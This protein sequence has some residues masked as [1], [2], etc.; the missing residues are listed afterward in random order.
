LFAKDNNLCNDRDIIPLENSA[1]V[2]HIGKRKA[3]ATNDRNTV[4]L[5]NSANVIHIGRRIENATI[6]ES[7]NNYNT[8]SQWRGLNMQTDVDANEYGHLNVR[9]TAFHDP[10]YSHT[11]GFQDSN[12]CAYSHMNQ[13]AIKLSHVDHDTYNTCQMTGDTGKLSHVDHDTYST[14][15]MTGDT[16]KHV[17][18]DTYSTCQMTGDTERMNAMKK[19]NID[20]TYNTL[21]VNE[22]SVTVPEKK[23]CSQVL[24]EP[25]YD[26][27]DVNYH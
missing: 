19:D 11:T 8:I 23:H 20:D 2:I 9:P 7:D 13:S 3:N 10:T 27:T 17:D 26:H 14:C 4:P 18:H 5:G 25:D 12:D 24:N 21:S 22:K 15:Q 1:N 16:G 6:D